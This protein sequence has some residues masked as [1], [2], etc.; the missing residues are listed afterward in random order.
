MLFVVKLKGFKSCVE[1]KFF[2]IDAKTDKKCSE[3]N[4]LID[5]TNKRI[6]EIRL[7]LHRRIVDARSELSQKN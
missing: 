3:L 2:R 6:D 7:E 1:C 5:E 4:E